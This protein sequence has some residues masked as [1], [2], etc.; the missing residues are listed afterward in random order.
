MP[1]EQM[2]LSI[3]SC[4]ESLERSQVQLLGGLLQRHP[5]VARRRRRRHLSS[6]MLAQLRSANARHILSAPPE[7]HAAVRHVAH[8]R[9]GCRHRARVARM[10]R[11]LPQ[12]RARTDLLGH[13]WRSVQGA[14]ARKAAWSPLPVVRQ[15]E[16]ARRGAPTRQRGAIA[17]ARVPY[18]FLFSGPRRADRLGRAAPAFQERSTRAQL[19]RT[20]KVRA[21]EKSGFLQRFCRAL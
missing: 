14:V 5:L 1:S 16:H 8:A 20:G 17:A 11:R 7:P 6:R 21:N 15:A 4:R 2:Q 19:R 9:S 12:L 3:C 18:C 13:R 10:V